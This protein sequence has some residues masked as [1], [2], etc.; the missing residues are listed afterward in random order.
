MRSA[1]IWTAAALVLS[2]AAGAPGEASAQLS[3]IDALKAAAKA[4][5]A[6]AAAS[7]ALGRALRRAGKTKEALEELRR[8]VNQ[9]R[10]GALTIDLHWELARTL[11]ARGDFGPAMIQCKVTGALPGGARPG[12]RRDRRGRSAAGARG[13]GTRRVR[14]GRGQARGDRARARSPGRRSPCR[15]GRDPQRSQ[16]RRTAHHLRPHRPRGE[17]A[18]SRRARG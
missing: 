17:P 14:G 6:D 16:R 9:T 5:P 8:G 3:Q 2:M 15:G 11:L 18:R 12:A 1:R 10:A 13:E 4:Q 7:L